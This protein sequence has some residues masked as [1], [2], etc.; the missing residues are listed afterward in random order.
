[1]NVD[2]ELVVM[3]KEDVAYLK[4][5]RQSFLGGTEINHEKYRCEF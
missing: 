5:L 2:G 4:V 3:W 1:M